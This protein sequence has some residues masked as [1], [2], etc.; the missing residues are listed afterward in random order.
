MISLQNLVW[1]NHGTITDINFI[2]I[3]HT[4]TDISYLLGQGTLIFICTKSIH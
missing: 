1:K 2:M 4:Q 3:T